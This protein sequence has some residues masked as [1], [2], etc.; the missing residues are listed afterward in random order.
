MAMT[1]DHRLY[2]ETQ[3]MAQRK[4]MGLAYVLWLFL[5]LLSIH[6]FYL[7][8]PGSAIL[9][10]ILNCLIVGL[11]W[12]LID[13]FLIPGM[14]REHEAKVRARLYQFAAPNMAEATAPRAGRDYDTSKWSQ[15]D[16]DAHDR[17]LGRSEPTL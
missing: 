5:G 14:T 12:T 3:V 11:I 7:E 16:R 9:Q 6:R 8:K 15:R 1:T 17:R 10:I 4:S 2:I 13:A